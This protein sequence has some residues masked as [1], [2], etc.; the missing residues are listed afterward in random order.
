MT[1]YIYVNRR[2]IEDSV[3]TG[4]R[5]KTLQV[6]HEGAKE[7]IE[8]YEVEILGPSKLVYSHDKPL[9]PHNDVRLAVITEAP[10][11]VTVT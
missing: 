1:T 10:I 4:V 5:L 8:A 9:V 2:A 6:W 11:K 7:N 3:R